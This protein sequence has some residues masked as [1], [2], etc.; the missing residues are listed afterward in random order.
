MK[1]DNYL[2]ET[3]IDYTEIET[4]LKNKASEYELKNI[5]KDDLVE[6]ILNEF[7][8][9]FEQLEKQ[10]VPTIIAYENA[11]ASKYEGYDKLEKQA[12]DIIEKLRKQRIKEHRE[13]L[14]KKAEMASLTIYFNIY[15]YQY[16][17]ENRDTKASK[18]FLQNEKKIKDKVE[19]F[20]EILEP[21]YAKDTKPYELI[22]LLKDMQENPYK[23][24]KIP[25]LGNIQKPEITYYKDNITQA[26]S[27]RLIGG[28]K[29]EKSKSKL[30]K[31]EIY[32][33]VKETKQKSHKQCVN[34]IDRIFKKLPFKKN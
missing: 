31:E 22:S 12:V 20:I 15:D 18:N 32:Q 13:A 17:S 30:S 10:A 4:F 16:Y 23:Y 7:G 28:K 29:E 27:N 19:K 11:D 24:A 6:F 14:Q 9:C 8:K 26:F 5:K 21:N 3:I 2:Q 33:K 1:N 25:K 34:E